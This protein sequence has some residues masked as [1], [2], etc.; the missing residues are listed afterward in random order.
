MHG[1]RLL[2]LLVSFVACDTPP[3]PP[4][5]VNPPPAAEPVTDAE[6]PLVPAID[7]VCSGGKPADLQEIYPANIIDVADSY[8]VD[9]VGGV[10]T[11]F[12]T[13]M[14]DKYSLAMF[15]QVYRASGGLARAKLV[16]DAGT[17]T[18]ALG[19][20]A[21]GYGAGK[22]VAT[23]LDVVALQN[24]QYNAKALGFA[25]RFETRLVSWDDTSAFAVVKPEERFDLIV[26]DP[27]QGYQ[28]WQKRAFPEVDSPMEKPKEAFYT[29]DPGACF[30]RSLIEGLDAHL[31]PEGYL[32][33][34][35]KPR[36]GKE[37]LRELVRSHNLSMTEVY[38]FDASIREGKRLLGDAEESPDLSLNATFYEVR[39]PQ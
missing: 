17:G 37:L 27:P 33:I 3:P 13:V 26:S 6:R 5:P 39:R 1:M 11:R 34:V 23:D 2:P 22:V 32:L 10:I 29:S 31:T 21:L 28:T 15:T 25:S 12:Q 38:A 14:F 7:F 24:A 30:L 4:E 20:A 19:L 35:M 8:Y 16:L 18:G 36:E 9:E